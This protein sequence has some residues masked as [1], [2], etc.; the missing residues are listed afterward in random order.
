MAFQLGTIEFLMKELLPRVKHRGSVM[1]LSRQFITTP[2]SEAKEF[3]ERSGFGTQVPGYDWQRPLSS[4]ELFLSFGFQSYDDIDFTPAEGCTIVHD[5]NQS[6]PA[7]LYERF[8]LVIEMGTLEH[9][10]D[11]RA[12]FESMVRMLKPG[13]TV[14]HFSPMTW[15]NHGFYNFSLTLFYD[16]YRYNGFG[17]VA[18]FLVA[19]PQD[20]QADPRIAYEKVAFVPHQFRLRVP[21]QSEMIVSCIATKERSLDKFQVPTQAAYDAAL[22]VATPLKQWS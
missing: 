4:R 3:L 5:L 8:D 9:I 21:P 10:F 22:R 14:F 13:G 6:V 16:V 17:E 7:E 2:P 12:V 11:V 20:W 15:I 18:F 1:S 19:F